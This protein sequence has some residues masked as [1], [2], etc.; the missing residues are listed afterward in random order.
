MTINPN[1]KIPALV[2]GD[3]TIFESLAINLYLAKNYTSA[4]YPDA[5]SLEA[6]VFQWSIWGISEIEPLQMPIVIQKFFV[7]EEKRND[8]LIAASQK[9]LLRPL[10]T[11]DDHLNGREW[12]IGDAFSIADL[13][14]SAVMLL[15]QMIDYD[16]SAFTEVTRWANTCYARPA[17]ARARDLP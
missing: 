14:L 7:A 8:K 9:Q 15:L 3:V 2:D 12:L 1:G 10:K 16:Y 17:L 5:L 11:L 6:Q 13:N 4:L